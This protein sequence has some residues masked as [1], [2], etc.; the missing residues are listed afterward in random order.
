MNGYDTFNLVEAC[1]WGVVAIVIAL[2]APRSSRQQ[3][4]GLILGVVAFLAFGV[5]DLLEIGKNGMLPLWLWGFKIACGIAILAA[6]YQWLGWRKFCWRDR[7]FLFGLG[8]LL[9]VLAVITL[10]RIL[11][12]FPPPQHS[13]LTRQLFMRQETQ[14]A[15]PACYRSKQQC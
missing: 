2:R 14:L 11:H 15:M 6:R 8:C 1:L 10:Q 5:S 7:E 13:S 9:A 3:R 4:T 12:A